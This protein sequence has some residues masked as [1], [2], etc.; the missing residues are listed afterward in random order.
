MKTTSNALRIS[1]AVLITL[2]VAGSSPVAGCDQYHNDRFPAAAIRSFAG[3]RFVTQRT[4]AAFVALRYQ[5][6]RGTIAGQIVLPSGLQV[7]TRIKVTL[8]GFRI[9]SLTVYT[10][11]K[12]RF[13][14]PGVS[15]GTFTLEVQA[16]SDMF[17]TVTQEVRVIYGAHP[18]LVITLREKPGAT[19]KSNSS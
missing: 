19:R 15:D 4:S 9:P 8:S 16:E 5:G 17:E 14:I 3:S 6:Q 18:M 12:G 2:G 10:D 13:A 11:N 7:T 1:L